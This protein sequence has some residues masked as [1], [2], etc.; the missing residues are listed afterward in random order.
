MSMG[1]RG[2]GEG[3]FCIGGAGLGMEGPEIPYFG[4]GGSIAGLGFRS[5]WFPMGDSVNRR[6]GGIVPREMAL[7]SREVGTVDL[8][9]GVGRAVDGVPEGFAG[10]PSRDE[11]VDNDGLTP[12][13]G[14]VRLGPDWDALILFVRLWLIEGLPAR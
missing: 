11:S 5:S 4:V 10:L 6:W 2:L 9:I 12:D 14:L 7:E 13:P 8:D 1:E 3:G